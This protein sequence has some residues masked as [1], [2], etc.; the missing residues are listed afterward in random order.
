MMNFFHKSIFIKY[1]HII[2]YFLI[3]I[4]V[5]GGLDEFTYL[6]QIS[7]WTIERKINSLT[8]DVLCRASV[9]TSGDWFSSRT[10]LDKYD[11]LI[12]IDGFSNFNLTNDSI[13]NQIK[14]KLKTC[15]LGMIYL[16]I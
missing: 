1:I 12:I 13:L 2:F 9:Y 7:G 3:P 11:Q 6:D 5:L 16:D 14:D 4:E 15:R 10:R 8:N